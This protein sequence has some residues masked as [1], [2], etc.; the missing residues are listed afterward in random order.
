MGTNRTVVFLLFLVI[1]EVYPQTQADTLKV[2]ELDEVVVSDSRFELKRE[3]SGKTVI[4]I[5]PEILE[6]NP[7]T[8]VASLLNRYSGIEIGGSRSRQGEVLGVFARGGRGRQVLVL[9]DGVRIADPSSFAQEYDLRLLS[10]ADIASIEIIKGAASTLYGTNAAAAVINIKTK[11]GDDKPLS[12]VFQSTMGT[13]HAASEQR[14]RLSRFSHS[15]RVSGTLDAFTYAVG[16]SHEFA[17][18]LSSLATAT[19]EEDAFSRFGTSVRLGYRVGKKLS[20]TLYGQEQR[21]RNDYDETFGFSDAP[22]RFVSK[23]LRTGISS[24]FTYNRGNLNLNTAYSE[25]DSENF[26]A[27]PSAF[28][29]DNI[30]LDLYNRYQLGNKVFTV[31]G[32]NYSEDRTYSVNTEKVTQFDPYLNLVFVSGKGWNMNTG[33]RLNRHSQYGNHGVY[34]INPSYRWAFKKGYLKAMASYS[35]SFI[36][37]SLAQLFGEFGANP[38]LEPETNRTLE[39]GLELAMTGRMRASLVYFNRKEQNAVIFNNSSF[40]YFNAA[41]EITVEGLELEVNWQP[42]KQLNLTGNYTFT[43]RAGDNAIRIPRHKWNL[44]LGYQFSPK[45]FGQILGSYTGERTDTDFNTLTDL[46][47]DPFFLLGMQLSYEALPDRL[48]LY[49]QGEN[50]GNSRFEEVAGFTTRGRNIAFGF[51]L[52]L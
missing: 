1:T 30:I 15:S 19:G 35:T 20:F 49:V 22:Y 51:Q 33:A 11:E 37:P 29:G 27:F 46:K 28:K 24:G 5:G 4:T 10:S 39:T 8:S 23:Q 18:G 7:G 44:N 3:N 32:V 47:L 42:S 12:G 34:N 31:L 21:L 45:V 2:R 36:A 13:N 41:S 6:R 9:L 26:S 52:S 16:V 17:N 14:Y 43:E 48:K 50:L 38:S 40:Q 25:Y